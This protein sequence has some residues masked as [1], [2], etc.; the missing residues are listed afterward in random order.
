MW[1][2]PFGGGTHNALPLPDRDL[3]VVVDE[4]VL[5]NK[6]DGYKPIWVFDNRVRSNP[7]SISTFPE[8]A[9]TDYL[10]VGGHFGPHNIHENRPGSFVSSDL[11]FATCQ[12]AGLRVFDIRNQYRPVEV[13]AMVPPAPQKLVDP[14]SNRPRVLHSADLFVDKQGIVYCTDFNAGLY[15]IQ[16]EG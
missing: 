3:L 12:N 11:I 6:E 13:A 15:T 2:P 7:T 10:A 4:A 8:P 1:A 9:D 14:R 5:D 16:F